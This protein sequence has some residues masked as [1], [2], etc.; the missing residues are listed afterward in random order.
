MGVGQCRE[1][2][3]PRICSRTLMGCFHPPLE[4]GAKQLIS[5]LSMR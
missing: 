5:V 3:L 1:P 2:I 4:G